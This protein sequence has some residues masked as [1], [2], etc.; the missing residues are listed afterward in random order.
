MQLLLLSCVA[1]GLLIGRSDNMR[2]SATSIP[3]P[4]V[5]II[6]T[7]TNPCYHRVESPTQTKADAASQ[8]T[9]MEVWGGPARGSSLP[10]VK[11]YRTPLP[12]PTRRGIEFC[13]PVAPTPGTGT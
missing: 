10:A 12:S 6:G 5:I 1:T 9:S 7:R 13:T 2:M 11:A 8:V 3:G 4:Q